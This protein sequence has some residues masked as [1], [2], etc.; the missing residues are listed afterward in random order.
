MNV[1]LVF[2][3]NDRQIYEDEFRD[4]LPDKFFDSHVHI[5]DESNYM[6]GYELPTKSCY[7]KF[8]GTFTLEQCLE[9][10]RVVLPDQEFSVNC[11][12]S[13]DAE[14]DLDAAA[15][16]TG[17]ISDNEHVFGMAMV[18]PKDNIDDVKRRIEENNLVGYKPYLNFVDWKEIKDITIEDMIT[19]EQMIYADEKG[20]A[21]TL[22][23]PRPGRLADSVNQKQMIDICN[24]YPNVKIIFAHIGRAYYM[25]NVIGFLD[26]ISNCENAY[27]DTAMVN[28]PGVL[29]YA[30][31]NFSR[32]RI[33]FGSDAPI[34][35]LRGKSV[36][37]NNQYAYLM[38]ENYAI[39]STIYDADNVVQFTTFFYE[40]LRGIKEAAIKAGLSRKELENF[41]YNNIYN[42]LKGITV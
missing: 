4:W 19:E 27:I 34:A 13:P 32:E 7:R 10:M 25:S 14:A 23:I 18:S 2:N 35:F 42:L 33:V 41:F 22:H 40:Q 36:E 38:G 9:I 1:E 37:I 11:F 24:K 3:E 17:S 30:F 15:F 29:E 31:N 12:G 6:A 26:G 20:L 16:Y 39:G 21:I 8:D 28:H 5:F